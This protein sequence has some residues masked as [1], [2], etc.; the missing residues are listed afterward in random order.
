MLESLKSILEEYHI[1][2]V[3]SRDAKKLLDNFKDNPKPIPFVMGNHL[4]ISDLTGP[5]DNGWEINYSTGL[6]RSLLIDRYENEVNQLISRESGFMISQ[7]YEAFE[8]FLKDIIA[9]FLFNNKD[10]INSRFKVLKDAVSED[11]SKEKIRSVRTGFNNEELFKVLR[12]NVEKFHRVENGENNLELNFH[13]WYKVFAT[14][15][16]SITHSNFEINKRKVEEWD[17]LHFQI[18]RSFGLI[19]EMDSAFQI[20]PEIKKTYR[21]LKLVAELGF[22]VFKSICISKN[23]NW[24][25][26]NNMT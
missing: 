6:T 19:S 26:Y 22:F 10:L 7:A 16:H 9:V 14:V 1:N 5:T 11:D 2:S 25:I 4:V 15:R 12:N 23:L 13:I 17:E 20:S 8:S 3:L 24:R 21:I 18:L